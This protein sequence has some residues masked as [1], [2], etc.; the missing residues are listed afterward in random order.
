MNASS[1]AIAAGRSSSFVPYALVSP[2]LKRAGRLVPKF[3][4]ETT[5]LEML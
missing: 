4:E 5:F 1:A 3:G 2:V